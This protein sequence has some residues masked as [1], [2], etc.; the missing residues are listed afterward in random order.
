MLLNSSEKNRREK[1]KV[2][3]ERETN[4]QRWAK[5]TNHFCGNNTK[6]VKHKKYILNV[7]L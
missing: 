3:M 6:K 4:R 2:G 1:D 7:Y 5:S